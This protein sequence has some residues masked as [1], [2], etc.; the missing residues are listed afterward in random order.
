M[1]KHWKSYLV[2]LSV[3]LSAVITPAAAQA[4]GHDKR[5]DRRDD[6]QD[7]RDDRRDEQGAHWEKLGERTVAGKGKRADVDT[8]LVGRREGLYTTL[9]I[10]VEKSDIVLEYM[11]VFFANGEVF[12]PNMRAIFDKN[13]RSRQ[14]DLPGNAR[15]IVK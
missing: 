5:E 15:T 13:T 14:I 6:R 10:K 12:Q 2:A 7:R 3:G 8:I 9:Q 1:T 4:D 11:K